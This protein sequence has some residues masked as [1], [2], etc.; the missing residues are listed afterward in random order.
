MSIGLFVEFLRS[1]G[2]PARERTAARE[3]AAAAVA[4]ERR[5]WLAVLEDYADRVTEQDRREEPLW[6]A[7]DDEIRRLR[8]QLRLPLRDADAEALAK[9]R[10]Q[11]REKRRAGTRERVRRHRERRRAT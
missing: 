8:K 3:A 11:A 2:M 6:I 4:S 9:R 5:F 10:E 1:G 7:L